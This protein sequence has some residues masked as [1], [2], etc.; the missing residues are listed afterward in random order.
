MQVSGGFG[1]E[2]AEYEVGSRASWEEDA[3]SEDEEAT[4]P[5]RCRA[6]GAVN[7]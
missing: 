6:Y 4:K 5:P 3:G 7:L 2:L 1:Q